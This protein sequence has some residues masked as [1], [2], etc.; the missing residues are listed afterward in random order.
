MPAGRLC[1]NAGSGAG[2]VAKLRLRVIW[3]KTANLILTRWVHE[4]VLD[5]MQARLDQMHTFTSKTERSR[6]TISRNA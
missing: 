2:G 5:T 4:G 1:R 3:R 6:A